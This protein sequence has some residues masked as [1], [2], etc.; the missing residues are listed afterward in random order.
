MPSASTLIL[1][2]NQLKQ[3]PGLDEELFEWMFNEANFLELP[4]EARQ[5][6]IIFDEMAIQTDIQIEK[7][8]DIVELI[9]FTDKGKEGDI[10]GVLR[11]GKKEQ[12][13]GTHVL[14]LLFLGVTGFRFPFA[15]FITSQIQASE[16]YSL[17]WKSVQCLFSFGFK[18]IYTCMDGAVCNRSFLHICVGENK[19][20]DY[21]FISK[22]PTTLHDDI[23]IMDISHVLKKIR[24]N[25]IKSGH[26]P[27]C[28]RLLTLPDKTT[29]QWQMFIDC[30]KWDQENALQLHRKLSNDHFFPDNQMKMRNHLAEDVL[31]ENMLFLMQ[32]Y[33]QNLGQKGQILDG[34]ISLLQNT[35]QMVSIFRDMRPIKKEDDQ[36][37]QIPR[38]VANWFLT[39]CQNIFSEDSIPQNN[40]NKCL[41]SLQC[42]EDIQSSLQGFISL[43]NNIL[44]TPSFYVTPGLINSDIIKNFFNQQRSTYNGPNTNPNSL[45]YRKTINS[46][47]I[48]QSTV[49]RKSNAGKD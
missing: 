49:S 25:I 22:S 37:L 5:G 19:N 9:G 14:Q 13:L 26:G 23:F 33:K 29:I 2:K 8:G 41:L 28:T 36:R 35:L 47:V 44:K 16:L 12:Q 31:N 34:C 7:N 43:C 27:K 46:I 20:F 21:N 39:W 24:N 3:N 38:E 42:C 15:H 18:V 11:S 1:Y 6:G 4:T 40:K 48:G 17:F 10:C 45:Q 30:F 32:Q